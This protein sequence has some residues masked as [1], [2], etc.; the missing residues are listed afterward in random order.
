MESRR[1]LLA[2]FFT[3][4]LFGLCSHF[5]SRFF[6]F[7][8]LVGAFGATTAILFHS[9]HIE[10]SN[11][12]NVCLGYIVSC[13]V[14]VLFNYAFPSNLFTFKIALSVSIAIYLMRTFKVFH[15]AGGAIALLST[16]YQFKVP[17]ELVS[18]FLGTSVLGPSLFYLIVLIVRRVNTVGMR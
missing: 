18:Y 10:I 11:Y 12:K 13:L 5:L 4:L 3:L 9:P 17:S 16:T 15:P 6:G 7:E 2:P 1:G 14:G 8:I